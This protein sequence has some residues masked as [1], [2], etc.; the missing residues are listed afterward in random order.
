ML[1]ILPNAYNSYL[2]RQKVNFLFNKASYLKLQVLEN[3]L[4][5]NI[6]N[7]NLLNSHQLAS[8]DIISVAESGIIT[9]SFSS[10]IDGGGKN[11]ILLPLYRLGPH[12]YVPLKVQINLNE[13]LVELN[14]VWAC[15]SSFTLSKKK[16]VNSNIGTLQS[17]YAPILCRQV[18]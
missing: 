7:K 15:T 6:L 3:A 17:K 4:Q 12:D 11:L 10:E 9:I 16:F 14:I 13:P 8:G 2:T 1:V 5:G 18:I